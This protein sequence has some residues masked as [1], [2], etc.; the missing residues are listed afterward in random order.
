MADSRCDGI[1]MARKMTYEL[2]WWIE[3]ELRVQFLAGTAGE[4]AIDNPSLPLF[5]YTAS[6]FIPLQLKHPFD[7]I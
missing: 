5:I 6:L 3:I 7:K 2:M 1:P 4:S